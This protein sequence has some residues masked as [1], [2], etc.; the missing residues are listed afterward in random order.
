MSV[1]RILK[2]LAVTDQGLS[3]QEKA[4]ARSNIGAQGALT[5]GPNVDITNNVI[6]VPKCTLSEGPNVHV[7]GITDPSTRVTDYTIS[8][9][10]TTYSAGS[11]LY[12]D[13]GVFSV[14]TP[15]PAP[16]SGSAGKVLT[17][18]ND[19]SLDWETPPSTSYSV[20]TTTEDGL[21]PK[22]GA[23]TDKFLKGD[24]T[25]QAPM[26]GVVGDANHPN[27]ISVDANGNLRYAKT[28][29][30]FWEYTFS[31]PFVEL[32]ATDISNGFVEFVFPL[33]ADGLA[34]MSNGN[35]ICMKGY[36]IEMA[37]SLNGR[38][39]SFFVVAHNDQNTRWLMDTGFETYTETVINSYDWKA[40]KAVGLCA[41]RNVAPVDAIL[42]V[43]L[44]TEVAGQTFTVQG[45]ICVSVF[46][47]ASGD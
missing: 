47:V 21:A 18:Q 31:R 10:D 7:V 42:R 44:T 15:V 41:D 29:R 4:T 2:A 6:S 32:T 22:S 45:Y 19:N 5:A 8:A 24:G 39:M 16:A 33:G 34:I 37:N 25:W 30:L 23:D 14:Q 20:F 38:Q 11:G 43:P 40:F 13:D 28:K 1:E 36:S 46:G 35:L 9:T 12:L 17:V 27:Y 26:T 3:D